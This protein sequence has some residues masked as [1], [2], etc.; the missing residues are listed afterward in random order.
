MVSESVQTETYRPTHFV[1]RRS[2]KRSVKRIKHEVQLVAF[3]PFVVKHKVSVFCHKS[4]KRFDFP[5]AFGACDASLQAPPPLNLCAKFEEKQLVQRFDGIT[6]GNLK[7]GVQALEQ[8]LSG[9]SRESRREKAQEPF[10]KRSTAFGSPQDPRAQW[11]VQDTKKGTFLPSGKL[12]QRLLHVLASPLV[13]LAPERQ[14]QLQRLAGVQLDCPPRDKVQRESGSGA[15]VLERHVA[16][17]DKAWGQGSEVRAA[18]QAQAS[19]YHKAFWESTQCHRLAANNNVP[20]HLCNIRQLTQSGESPIRAQIQSAVNHQAPAF[21][22]TVTLNGLYQHATRHG[23]ALDSPLEQ[24][25]RRH[26][27]RSLP[28]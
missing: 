18:V 26:H 12:A 14:R 20:S 22:T 2:V 5:G 3:H 27:R 28:L 8:F 23:L 10:C 17:Y 7:N 1:G 15:T 11:Q 19:R 16:F 24:P 13:N 6:T 4:E 25:I 9:S 21:N